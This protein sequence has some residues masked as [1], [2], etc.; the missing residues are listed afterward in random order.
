MIFTLDAHH[1]EI[2]P[3]KT[4]HGD[5]H[6]VQFWLAS[7][8][9]HR[10][11]GLYGRH[12]RHWNMICLM[13]FTDIS[14]YASLWYWISVWEWWHWQ[15]VWAKMCM[16]YTDLPVFHV[17]HYHVH[18]RFINHL[19]DTWYCHMHTVIDVLE[20][21]I[22]HIWQIRQSILYSLSMSLKCINAN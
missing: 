9:D 11:C 17:L 2:S 21:H 16:G 19:A 1:A 20:F 10:S 22:F 14:H 6:I 12:S 15:F 8:Q 18:C 4:V 3:V 13:I 5:V 7:F